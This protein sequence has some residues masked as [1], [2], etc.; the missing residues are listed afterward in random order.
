MAAFNYDL[1]SYA[2][3]TAALADI[4]AKG[5]DVAGDPVEGMFFYD[6]TLKR[7]K[8]WDG[9]SWNVTDYKGGTINVAKEGGDYTTLEEGLAAAAL[10]SRSV[11]LLSPGIYS[12][13]NPLTMPVH[14]CITVTGRHESTYVAC[15]NAGA[16]GVVMATD[17]E[18]QG[19]QVRDA[20]G[21]GSAGY[22]FPAGI[23]DAELHDCKF[24]DCDIGFLSEAAGLDAAIF[25]RQP[26]ASGGS[27]STAYK[28]QGGGQ[29]FVEG[30]VH[31]DGVTCGTFVECDGLG[32]KAEFYVCRIQGSLT[33]RCGTI[34]NDAEL[35]M[36]I[37]RITDAS[38]GFFVE[39]TGGALSLGSSQ[40][41]G[42]AG[43]QISL[44]D[45]AGVYGF[46]NDIYYDDDLLVKGAAAFLSGIYEASDVSSRPGPTVVGE[47]WLGTDPA[48]QI[49]L[50]SYTRD[51]ASSGWVSGLDV[52]DGGGLNVA[53]SSGKGMV[54]T[55]TG[56]VQV[57]YAGGTVAVTDDSQFWIFITS[58][59]VLSQQHTE[60][61]HAT[62]IVLALG[63]AQ[64]GA[65]VMLADHTVQ[66][67][68]DIGRRHDY[69]ADVIGSI[70]QSGE[71]K[72]CGRK[73]F[74]QLR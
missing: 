20:S 14:C 37:T 58:A 5:W 34:S 40:F 69:L 51:T 57:E 67:Q 50:A 44:A 54:N 66:M 8:A 53:V 17:T 42:V 47:L 64:G 48:E 56:V 46:L 59:G 61:D 7:T 12:E 26:H 4:V 73:F 32:S 9:T 1:G 22:H 45:A 19:L 6:T 71:S 30:A 27:C 72:S 15:Q 3:S 63:R 25:I 13:N 24:R 65:I 16:H 68:H 36:Q 49:P 41:T 29:M 23:H 2:N 28:V 62:N 74:D 35:E 39:A 60:P 10:L 31:T 55:G 33:T 52:T 11:I 43:T 21:A 38:E 18:V 70:W